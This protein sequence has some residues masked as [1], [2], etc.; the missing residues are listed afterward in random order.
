MDQ[1][2]KRKRG[3]PRK[4][5]V[6]AMPDPPLTKPAMKEP[7]TAEPMIL[8]S[9]P[10]IKELPTAP[11]SEPQAGSFV[12]VPFEAIPEV[13]EKP[14]IEKNT[15]DK[16]ETVVNETLVHLPQQTYQ[17]IEQLRKLLSLET[18]EETIW[19]I[20]SDALTNQLEK[21]I[22]PER[23]PE[24]KEFF[25]LCQRLQTVY[26]YSLVMYQDAEFRAYEGI[27]VLLRSRWIITSRLIRRNPDAFPRGIL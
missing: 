6:T 15:I 8:S 5:P 23:D 12:A 27:N 13:V 4:N 3:R 25:A 19:V 2:V 24:I 21:T 22:V 10:I 26:K 9:P 1:P 7:V 16:E 14:H 20:V 17:T 11:E 18:I